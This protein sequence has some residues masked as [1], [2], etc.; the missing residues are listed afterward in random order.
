[1]TVKNYYTVLGVKQTD[2]EDTIKKAYRS[3]AKKYHPD[4]NQNDK[5]AETKMQEIAEAWEILGDEKKRKEYNQRLAGARFSIPKQAPFAAGVRK[6]PYSNRSMTQEEFMNMSRNFDN[7]LSRDAIKN[8]VE[9]SNSARANPVKPM[10]GATFFEKVIG[11]K[12]PKKK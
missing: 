6:A 12:G 7:T 8:S 2:S 9:P 1:M 11:F 5:A 4:L 3:L 10:S